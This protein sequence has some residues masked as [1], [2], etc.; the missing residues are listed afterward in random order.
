MSKLT[1]K[2][3]VC[4]VGYHLKPARWDPFLVAVYAFVL[5]SSK[6][7]SV[8]WNNTDSSIDTSGLVELDG[9][10]VGGVITLKG[11]SSGQEVE[12]V[13]T[14]PTAARYFSFAPIM[15]TGMYKHRRL[16]RHIN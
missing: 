6:N 4:H 3:S 10:G 2:K 15:F 9:V 12:K 7:F 1:R 11:S 14:T 8:C 16:T 5:K 13:Y